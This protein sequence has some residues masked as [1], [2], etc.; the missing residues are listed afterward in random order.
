MVKGDINPTVIM[1]LCD[2]DEWENNNINNGDLYWEHIHPE[3]CSRCDEQLLQTAKYCMK[4]KKS[5]DHIPFGAIL[6]I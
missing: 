6:Q 1:S 2:R 4:K 5:I 3:G